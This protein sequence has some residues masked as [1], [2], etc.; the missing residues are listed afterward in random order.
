M[1]RLGGTVMNDFQITEGNS[2]IITAAIH[3][4]HVIRGDLQPYLN[5]TEHERM[6]EEDPYTGYLADISDTHIVVYTSRFEVDLNRPREKAVYTNPEDAWGLFVWKWDPSREHLTHSLSIYDEFYKRVKSLI[7]RTIDKHGFF[8]V[9]DLHAYNYRRSNPHREDPTAS[10]PEINLGTA[11][12]DLTWRPS[13]NIFI[14]NMSRQFI[15]GHRPDIRENIKFKGGEFSRWINRNFGDSGFALRIDFK[16][17]FMDEW[18]G[19]ADIYHL[20]DIKNALRNT[21][22]KL[23]THHSQLVSQ[24]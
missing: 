24:A 23:V 6:R 21:A 10:T 20:N 7:R 14:E 17:T 1:C 13:L 2:P 19:R 12:I 11:S 18:T 22:V 16:K 15:K 9:L 8:I 4:G 5:L 3:D